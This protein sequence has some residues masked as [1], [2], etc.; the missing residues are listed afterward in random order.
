MVFKFDLSS[1][2]A[3]THIEKAELSFY[4]FA[5]FIGYQGRVLPNGP[6]TIHAITTP[7]EEAKVTWQYPP[8]FDETII[9][10][11]YEDQIRVWEHFDITDYVKDIING[12]IE[13]HGLLVKQ[14][15]TFYSRQVPSAGVQ[16]Y[17]SEYATVELRPK[18]TLHTDKSTA[19]F[20]TKITGTFPKHGR[21]N[22]E[23]INLRGQI[24]DSFISEDINLLRPILKKRCNSGFNIILI[25]NFKGELVHKFLN[26]SM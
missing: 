21:Y 10:T 12:K 1:I 13:N 6:K 26:K 3:N 22:I 2:P 11:S 5:N 17:S 18:L 24:V 15:P 25:K 19:N 4:T 23:V 8:E 9:N 14:V 20:K 7:W 16:I